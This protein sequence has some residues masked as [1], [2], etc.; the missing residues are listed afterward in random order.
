MQLI[1][2]QYDPTNGVIKIDNID[3]KDYQVKHLRSQISVVNQEPILFSGTIRDNIS[4]G[5]ESSHEEIVEAAGKAQALPFIESH[6]DGFDREVGIKGS[7]LSGGQKQRIAIARA[8]I[9]KP[10][11]LLLDEATSALDAS[12]ESEVLKQIRDLISE[13]TCITIAHRLKTIDNCDY[14]MVLESG[15]VM[16]LGERETLKVSGGY[17]SSMIS[18]L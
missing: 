18:A 6:Q 17:Y 11:I 8:I 13:A 4:Y 14:I 1:L 15:K 9:R 7:M 2:R 12:T 10:K 3:I 16:E 5:I